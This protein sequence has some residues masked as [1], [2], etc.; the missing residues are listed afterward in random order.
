[1]IAHPSGAPS[2]TT[3]IGC[4]TRFLGRPRGSTVVAAQNTVR[5]V[6]RR[7]SSAMGV[8]L[9]TS[10]P[11]ILAIEN[12]GAKLV[13]DRPA[14]PGRSRLVAIR[15]RDPLAAINTISLRIAR[16]VRQPPAETDYRPLN[17]IF[18]IPM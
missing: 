11:L 3:K 17:L 18:S 4:S 16:G 10:T 13:P 12:A 2:R 7:K 6:N 1:V 8:K 9:S 14:R 5:P 15:D